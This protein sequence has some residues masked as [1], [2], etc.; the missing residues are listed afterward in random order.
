[1]F[2]HISLE[3]EIL[4][5]PQYFGPQLLEKV[6][7]KLYTE[8]E[9]TCTGKYGFVI[10]VTTIDS[11]GAGL[12]L[13]GQGFVVYPVKYKAIVFRPFKG[14]VLDAVVRQVNKVGM[15]AE[16]GPLS[17]FISHHSIPAEMEFCPNVNPQC[18]KTKDEDVVIHAEGE[19][20]LKIVGTRVDASGIFAIGTLMDDYLGL[21]SN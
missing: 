21:I 18:Y 15:F 1:M 6:K 10:A 4:L 20:R 16:I 3:H 14:E 11:I 17:C 8:V 13:P 9:G 5:H 7:T 12:I 19:I 2:Y